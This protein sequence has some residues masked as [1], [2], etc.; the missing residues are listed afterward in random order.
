MI[1]KNGAGL[2]VLH[3]ESS[4]ITPFKR[5]KMDLV[6]F[7]IRE[8]I[9]TES[10]TELLASVQV[11]FQGYHLL[12]GWIYFFG[13]LLQRFLFLHLLPSII[14]LLL[15]GELRFPPPSSFPGN[16]EVSLR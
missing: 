13:P 9:E 2:F 8:N 10:S 5:G 11:T 16:T 3:E 12:M 14:S 6:E 4:F 15:D 7:I 1:S